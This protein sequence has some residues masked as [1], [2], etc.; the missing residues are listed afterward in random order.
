MSQLVAAS[1]NRW[2]IL[3]V[4]VVLLAIIGFAATT[5]FSGESIRVPDAQTL[6]MRE[7]V[8]QDQPD[9]SVAVKDAKT[10]QKIDA[11]TGEAG[12]ARGTLRGFARD[13]RARGIGPE[14]PLQLMGRADGRLTLFDP[15][16]GRIVDL[17]S[18]GPT[19][20]AIFARMLRPGSAET[21]GRHAN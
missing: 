16:T 2:P 12:F 17:E 14:A 19:N 21:G 3:A 9:G 18:F 5:R 6:V 8:F 1:S 10:G 11:I 15:E 13:R 7:L 4:G 20:A